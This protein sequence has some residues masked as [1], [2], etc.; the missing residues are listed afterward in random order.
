MRLTA[1]RPTFDPKEASVPWQRAPGSVRER[2]VIL[3][4]QAISCKCQSN[5]LFGPSVSVSAHRLV[6]DLLIIG[7]FSWRRLLR[8]RE[9][10]S[11]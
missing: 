8:G 4:S 1:R 7:H 6:L 3:L 11:H 2:G 5:Q 9:R 10:I